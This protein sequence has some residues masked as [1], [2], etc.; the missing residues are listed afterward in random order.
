MVSERRSSTVGR[1]RR[2]AGSITSLCTLMPLRVRA[3][4]DAVEVRWLVESKPLAGLA[5]RVGD[6]RGD[7]GDEPVRVW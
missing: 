2:H 5:N 4:A 7:L 1:R 6:L 3:L